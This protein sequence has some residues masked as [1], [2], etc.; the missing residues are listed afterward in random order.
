[1]QVEPSIGSKF[2]K[3]DSW[4]ILIYRT[5]SN[6]FFQLDNVL[7]ARSGDYRTHIVFNCLGIVALETIKKRL[8]EREFAP[9]TF[10]SLCFIE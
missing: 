3:F 9:L 5:Q 8:A 1:M 4:M 10:F 6:G 7:P 2:G